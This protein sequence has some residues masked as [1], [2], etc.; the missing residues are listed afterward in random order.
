MK[1]MHCLKY[2]NYHMHSVYRNT[3]YCKYT[4][5]ILVWNGKIGSKYTA[6]RIILACV[7]SL[8]QVLNIYF[9][10]FPTIPAWHV[11][12]LQIKINL[13]YQ[14]HHT[15]AAMTYK[16]IIFFIKVSAEYVTSE[17]LLLNSLWERE[18]ERERGRQKKR[19]RVWS[20][21]SNF[22]ISS[23]AT[24]NDT[25]STYDIKLHLNGSCWSL[26]SNA[27]KSILFKERCTFFAFFSFIIS[28]REFWPLMI[29]F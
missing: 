3:Q 2:L 27:I 21:W 14:I 1:K 25:V 20:K 9:V 6:A 5:H 7:K 4:L 12:P 17:N 28:G 11:G 8:Q 26:S 22:S 18:R 29:W 16:D 15:K 10:F 24:T 19:E 23:L 13:T